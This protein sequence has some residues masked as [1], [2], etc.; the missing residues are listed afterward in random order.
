MIDDGTVASPAE[1]LLNESG[2]ETLKRFDPSAPIVGMNPDGSV[3]SLTAI[4]NAT[5][6]LFNNTITFG[7]AHALGKVVIRELMPIDLGNGDWIQQSLLVGNDGTVVQLGNRY[8]GMLPWRVNVDYGRSNGSLL[9][10]HDGLLV[11]RGYSSDTLYDEVGLLGRTRLWLALKSQ[12]NDS[13]NGRNV[14][15]R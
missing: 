7:K 5:N 13:L 1:R 6:E 9:S 3:R 11:Y 15:N 10:R 2:L 14:R 4:E 12:R 8:M